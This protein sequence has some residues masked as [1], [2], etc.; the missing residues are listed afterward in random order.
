MEIEYK[1]KKLKK[2]LSNAAEIKKAFGINAKRISSR[3]DEIVSCPNLTVLMQIP[4]ANCHSL[5]GERKGE[6]A[7]DVS[8]NFRLIF[9]L[10][11]NPLPKTEDGSINTSLITEIRILEIGD[12]H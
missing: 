8:R 7:V 2:Q 12:Y 5:S 1:R 6:W 3:L 4:A 10:N 11:H 9:E